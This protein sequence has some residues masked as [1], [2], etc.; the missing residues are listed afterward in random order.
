MKKLIFILLT[1]ILIP[2]GT[3][4]QLGKQMAKYHK[5]AGVSVT[6]LDKSLYGLYQNI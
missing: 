5:K 6:Q 4:A 2:F 1:M 3:Y